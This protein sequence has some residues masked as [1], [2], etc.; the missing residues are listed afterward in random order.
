M[1]SKNQIS[2]IQ[3]LQQKKHRE[4]YKLFIAEGPK[5]VQEFINAGF[6]CE[7]F[8]SVNSAFLLPSIVTHVINDTMLR[9]ISALVTP[10]ECLGVF[11]IP[12]RATAFS[13]RGVVADGLRDPGNLGTLIRLCD[14]FN[15]RT[16]VLSED[17]VDCY[18]P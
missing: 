3:K 18:N 7:I 10:N 17:S 2:L 14:W 13:G 11:R 4:A 8:T 6:T 16:L 1:V 5:V 12:E 9:K 15:I